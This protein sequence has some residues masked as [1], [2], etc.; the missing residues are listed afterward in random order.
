MPLWPNS[1]PTAEDRLAYQIAEV[2]AV[3]GETDKAFEWLQI[4]FDTHDTGIL[5]FWSIPC[6]A[7]CAR[8]ALQSIGRK[9]EFP[10]NAMSEKPSFFAEPIQN[11]RSDSTR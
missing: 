4:A 11:L 3:R 9:D 2:Y 7:I 1:S 8:S 6:C 5:A 10:G